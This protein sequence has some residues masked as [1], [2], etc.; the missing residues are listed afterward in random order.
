[1]RFFKHAVAVAAGFLILGA[2]SSTAEELIPLAGIDELT[3]DGPWLVHAYYRNLAQVGQV[4]DWADIWETH[5][6]QQYL[7]AEVTRDEAQTFLD[8]G[9][10]LSLQVGEKIESSSAQNVFKE[11]EATVAATATASSN[12]AGCTSWSGFSNSRGSFP[13]YRTVEETYSCASQLAADRPTLAEYFK[14]G[15]SWEKTQNAA[16]GY[17]INILKLTNSAVTPPDGADKPKL[18]M[19][20]A[21]HA[22]EYT[23][24]ELCT[25][26][27]EKLVNGHGTDPDIT[28]ILDHQEVHLMLHTN[29]DGRKRAE[30]GLSWRK[31]TNNQYCSGSNSRGADLNRN[32]EF[33]WGCCGGSSGNECDAT[34]RGSSAASEPEIQTLQAYVRAIF[35]DQRD[36]D[37]NAAA[38]DN[39]TGIALDI[40]SYSELV[41]WPWGFTSDEAPNGLQL[42]TLGRKLAYYNGYEPK[43]VSLID[44]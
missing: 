22:R 24:A 31:N 25:R 9:F 43:Q 1:M 39:A 42:Q 35:P 8:E 32:F 23:T 18:F 14:I 12:Q 5:E 10:Q 16:N 29:P 17:D 21:L 19:N 27:A 26:F 2:V 3:G 37:V 44:F 20:C 28:W 33:G 40:H 11:S 36:D 7:L 13:C 38:P 4:W 41:L 6:N 30:T 34:F 15:D